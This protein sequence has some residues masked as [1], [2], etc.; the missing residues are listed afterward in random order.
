MKADRRPGDPPYLEIQIHPAD[1]RRGVRTVFLGRTQAY[2]AGALVAVYLL[3][4]GTGLIVAPRV[5]SGLLYERDYRERLDE[6]TALGERL[7][8]KVRLLVELDRRSDQV[9][10]QLSRILLAYGLSVEEQTGEGGYPLVAPQAPDSIYAGVI[11]QGGRVEARMSEQLQVLDAFLEE[12]AA[13]EQE[14][15]E[16][17]RLTPSVSPLD[18]DSFVLTS[19]FGS[20]RSPFTK[21]L[22]FH[23]GID[24]AAKIGTPVRAPADGAVVFAGRYPLRESVAWWRYGNMVA[25]RHGEDFV[26][27]YGHCDEVRVRRGQR[28]EQGEVIATVGNTGWSTS[29]HLH[30]EVRRRGEDGDFQPLDPRIYM[31]DHRW[32]DEERILVRARRAPEVY[33]TEPLPPMIAR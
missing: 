9:S 14:N 24:L 21:Q 15:L 3:V 2:A 8:E 33:E 20:R 11:R 18:S 27:I 13:F 28:V 32:R 5:V 30:Y 31:L 4:V 16:R 12:L 6:R 7:Q 25:L 22:H 29:P 17:V 1:I 26:T 23:S 19:A 10:L